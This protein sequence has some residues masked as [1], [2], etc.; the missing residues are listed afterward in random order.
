MSLPP[1]DIPETSQGQPCSESDKDPGSDLLFDSCSSSSDLVEV[2]QNPT[3]PHTGIANE[4]ADGKHHNSWPIIP[5]YCETTLLELADAEDGSP[6]C[7]IEIVPR[8]F[9]RPE[10][11]AERLDRKSRLQ[12]HTEASSSNHDARRP[13]PELIRINSPLILKTL[14]DID[15]HVDAAAPTVMLQPFKF[16]VD[17]E[18]EIKE[19]IRALTKEV[20]DAEAASTPDRPKEEIEMSTTANRR[21]DDVCQTLQHMQCLADFFNHYIKPTLVRLSGNTDPMIYFSDL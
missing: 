10:K 7:A 3:S 13:V 4:R 20:H 1:S 15:S 16:L 19:C 9:S 2:K 11:S 5:E 17:Y 14:A 12:H 8:Q 6:R 21:T 18:G